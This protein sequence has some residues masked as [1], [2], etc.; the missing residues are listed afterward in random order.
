MSRRLQA[1]ITSWEDTDPASA[2]RGTIFR[3]GVFQVPSCMAACK[4]SVQRLAKRVVA[5]AD[6][7]AGR[8]VEG[9]EY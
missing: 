2:S 3:K 8:R 1:A 7:E 5:L 4:R 6:D 9:R